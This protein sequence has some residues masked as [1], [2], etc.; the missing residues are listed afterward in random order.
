MR[1][2]PPCATL[3]A[4]RDRAWSDLGIPRP[5]AGHAA[6]L[7]LLDPAELLED[8]LAVG[9]PPV[10]LVRRLTRQ[11]QRGARHHDRMFTVRIIDAGDQLVVD[12]SWSGHD[13]GR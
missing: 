7:S 2:D 13:L 3:A 8:L 4:C 5:A 9:H 11:Q 1:R 10:D 12:R 6:P